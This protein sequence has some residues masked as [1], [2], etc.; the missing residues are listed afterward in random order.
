VHSA[1]RDKNKSDRN[2]IH[3]WFRKKKRNRKR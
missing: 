1:S 3:V 2:R